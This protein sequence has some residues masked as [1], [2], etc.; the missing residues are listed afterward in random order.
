MWKAA[1]IAVMA[2]VAGL[3]GGLSPATAQPGAVPAGPSTATP[4]TANPPKSS[5]ER[6]RD[7]PASQYVLIK[8]VVG[9]S[10]GVVDARALPIEPEGYNLLKYCWAAANVLGDW[11]APAGLAG[12]MVVRALETH[13]W[14]RDLARAGYPE[15]PVAESIGRYEAALVA[16]GFTDVARERALDAL[17]AELQE[18]RRTAPGAA[19]IFSAG[20]CDRARRSMA[21]EYKTAPEGGRAR[22]I[23]YVLHQ[24]CRAQ[25]LDADDPVR[26]DYWMNAR[27]DGPMSFAGETVYSVRWPDGTVATGRFDPDDSRDAGQVTLRER[28]LKK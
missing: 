28:P 24:I 18:I 8:T 23:P 26:C 15:T 9:Q 14:A 17:T 25:Q 6:V 16:A 11:A 21:I 12:A 1:T 2:F 4:S 5:S 7:N 27:A 13:S 3:A 22:F 10:I 19:R 20:R